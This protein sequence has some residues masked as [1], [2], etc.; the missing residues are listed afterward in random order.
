MAFG[1]G[2]LHGEGVRRRL[3]PILSRKPVRW[4]AVLIVVAGLLLY[5]GLTARRHSREADLLRADPDLILA[6]PGL[7]D[8]AL[9]IGHGVFEQH[10]A[11]CHGTEGRG[12]PGEPD[13]TDADWIYGEGRVSEIEAIVRYGIRSGN[14]KGWN[15]AS[16][17]VYASV[18]P[19]VAEPLPSLAPGEVDDVV[20]LLLSFEGRAADAQAVERG[21]AVYAK[22]G[23][24]DCHGND[25]RGEG[26]VGAP[27]LRDAIT[28]YGGTAMALRQS[29][30][31]GR[32][33]VSPSFAGTLTSTEIRAV[34]VYVKSLS[35]GVMEGP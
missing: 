12:S 8:A 5:A 16:M 2:S 15:L 33:G 31:H 30:E 35:H 25:A 4:V 13:L 32:R 26:A 1:G 9:N 34:A 24:W 10:C 3:L 23:C 21:R 14:P 7:R 6:K 29:V 28:L 20:Q 19:Y 17:P 18:R 27:D 11:G 22:A